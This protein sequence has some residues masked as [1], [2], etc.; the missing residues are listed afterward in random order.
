M[1]KV[2]VNIFKVFNMYVYILFCMNVRYI[3]FV[4]KYIICV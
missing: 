4:N 2:N 1:Y 3:I